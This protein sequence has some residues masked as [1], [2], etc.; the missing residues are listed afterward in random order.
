[1]NAELER[2]ILGD[3]CPVGALVAINDGDRIPNF[4]TKNSLEVMEVLVLRRNLAT[5]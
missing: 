2:P 3:G 4:Q 1:M 5:A